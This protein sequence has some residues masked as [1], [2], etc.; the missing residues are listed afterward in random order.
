MEMALD[1]Q[2]KIRN[3]VVEDLPQLKSLYSQAFPEEDLY[4]LVRELLSDAWPV[5]S[6]VASHEIGIV[7]HVCFTSCKVGPVENDVSLLAPLCVSPARQGQGIGSALVEHGFDDLRRL[8]VGE[9]LVLGDPVYY[10]RFG[11]ETSL[12]IEPPFELPG[13]WSGAW[14]CLRLF[15]DAPALS[16]K[17][18]VPAPWNVR[19][20]WAP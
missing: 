13:E 2:L 8:G 19:A 10:S 6:F 7:G 9:V 14:Q 4:P 5:R 3:C 1:A 16:G 15:K 18:K 17:L 12:G 20:L 11:F